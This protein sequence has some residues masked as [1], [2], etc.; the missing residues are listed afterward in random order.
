MATEEWHVGVRVAPLAIRSR[1]PNTVVGIKAV[2]DEP[3]RLAPLIGLVMD[4]VRHDGEGVT[5]AEINAFNLHILRHHRN[6]AHRSRRVT[7]QRFLVSHFD[8]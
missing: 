7:P 3:L 8:V 4:E 6:T 5:L 1:V 2:R